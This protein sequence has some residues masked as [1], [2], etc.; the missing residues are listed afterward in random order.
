MYGE[1]KL[2]SNKLPSGKDANSHTSEFLGSAISDRDKNQAVGCVAS[3]KLNVLCMV[4]VQRIMV[5]M[6]CKYIASF[7][8]NMLYHCV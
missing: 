8:H 1:I 6:P 3:L 4:F 5:C 7:M 2:D